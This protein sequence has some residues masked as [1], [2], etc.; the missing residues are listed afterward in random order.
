MIEDAKCGWAS[1]PKPRNA[2]E[3]KFLAVERLGAT[4][5]RPLRFSSAKSAHFASCTFTPGNQLSR[6][7]LMA[8]LSGPLQLAQ[9]P[10]AHC[11]AVCRGANPATLVSGKGDLDFRIQTHSLLSKTND[12]IRAPRLIFALCPPS[13]HKL[14]PPQSAGSKSAATHPK[15]VCR[16]TTLRLPNL[17][18]FSLSLFLKRSS[19]QRSHET[20]P[21]EGILH[22]SKT[23][24]VLEGEAHETIKS[25]RTNNSDAPQNTPLRPIRPTRCYAHTFRHQLGAWMIL[26]AKCAATGDG[27]A[28]GITEWNRECHEP[29]PSLILGSVDEGRRTEKTSGSRAVSGKL[30]VCTTDT[31]TPTID[32]ANGIE[33]GCGGASYAI[34]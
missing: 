15:S 3:N 29:L 25:R 26:I 7:P 22:S 5:C 6:I 2:K 33:G 12:R 28:V 34:R 32:D 23:R 21:R 30:S 10:Q 24:L 14:L 8:T 9:L 16:G 31:P 17:H 11:I 13:S 1:S 27:V 18:P 4:G 19:Q 20:T